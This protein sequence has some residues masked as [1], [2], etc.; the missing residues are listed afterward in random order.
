MGSTSMTTSA[1]IAFFVCSVISVATFHICFCNGI[2]SSLN[3]THNNITCFESEREA[4]VKFKQDLIDPSNWLSSWDTVDDCCRWVG[5]VCDSLTGHVHEIRLQNPYNDQ[6]Y[7]EKEAEY[8]AYLRYKLRGK[9]NPS[10][11]NLKHLQYLDLSNNNFEGAPIPTFIGS[12]ATLRYLNL[13]WAGFGGT[14][15]PQLGN[16]TTI[17]Y[18]DLG[19]NFG[20]VRVGNL[21]WLAGLV[22]LQHLD[23]SCVDLS[24][25]LDWLWVTSNLPSLVELHLSNCQLKYVVSPSSTNKINFT[26]LDILD[27]SINDLGPSTLGWVLSLNNL[28]SLDLSFCRFFGPVTCGFQN[29]T[30]L[31]VLDL[32]YNSFNSTIPNCL[33]SLSH[34][35][36]LS[37]EGNYLQGVISIAVENLTSLVSLD[38]KSNQLQ[39]NMPTSLGKLCKLK[40]IDL[41]YNEFSGE[42]A[43]VLIGFSR[44]KSH[45]IEVFSLHRNHLLGQL[46][47]ELG[48]LKNLYLFDISENSFSGPI[49]VSIGRLSSLKWLCLSYNKFNGTIPESFWQLAKLESLV[50]NDNALEG[51]VSDVNFANLTTL[52]RLHAGGNSITLKASENWVPP[53]QV[54]EL[55]LDSWLLGPQF[56]L[57]LPSQRKLTLLSIAN[58]RIS[59]SIPTWIWPIFSKL[60]YAN[61]SRNQICGEIP[62]LLN[63]GDP[64]PLIDLSFNRLN[65]SLPLIPSNL[66]WLDLSNNSFSGSIYHVL[67][68][69][70][71]EPNKSLSFLNL[72]NN[73]LSG[74]IP[75]CW[76]HWPKLRVIIL[77]NN[78]LVGGIPSSMGQLQ[79]L[80]SLH[81]RHNNLSGELPQTLQNCSSLLIIDLSENRFTGSIPPWMGNA[82][83]QLVVLNLRSNNFW[84]N[85]AYE[86]CCLSSLQILDIASNNISGHV[87][88]CFANFSAMA[89]ING[90]LVDKLYYKNDRYFIDY[91][92]SNFR[93]NAFLVTK[94]RDVEYSTTLGL[95][96]SM[97]LS[98]NKLSGEIPEELTKLVRLW[99]L[100]LSGNHLTRRI[101]RNIGDMRQLESVDFSRNQL[102]GS[103]PSSMSSLTFLSHLNLS[104]NNL[105]GTIPSSTQLQSM[106]ESSFLGNKLCGPPLPSCKPNKTIAPNVV[107]RG[108]EEEGDGFSEV[109]FFA[110]IAL[111]FAVGFWVVLGPLL[112]KRSWRI[113]YFKRL[114]GVSLI[115]NVMYR[116]DRVPKR[117]GGKRRQEFR[118]LK[119]ELAMPLIGNL[120]SE[121]GIGLIGNLKLGLGTP[122]IGHLKSRFCI[123]T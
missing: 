109:L 54:E 19:Y 66:V 36:S 100:N 101:P 44:C 86:L 110:S 52:R 117:P 104:Y 18:L 40:T 65:G 112:F 70:G 20:G 122:L 91:R 39:G 30:S 64:Y 89:E 10:L 21:Q 27:L 32:A 81:L 5:V 103:I 75:D 80:Q 76:K 94:G 22:L 85:L 42:V 106:T 113:A 78:N 50:V 90:N 23:M 14:I 8:Q 120:K 118:H 17:R 16:I 26:S 25:A 115:R 95:V 47:D 60:L 11:L 102:S 63:V 73:L 71:E 4:L 15:P 99:S 87:P 119:S 88:R 93:D 84:G 57:W 13:S 53:F 2:S 107:P 3:H 69:K 7:F 97:D 24:K 77:E 96:K 82:L 35:E 38:L 108:S 74:N 92:A 1:P 6:S 59:D 111:G 43:D 55:N 83:L 45:M 123:P 105:T 61:L 121:I 67:C 9:V 37:L 98:E 51:V 56:P 72:G 79:V 49:P 58:T 46:P 31:R 114:L 12:I 116:R 68:G 34:L 62:S 41:S 48:Q 33:Y 29:M 28:V